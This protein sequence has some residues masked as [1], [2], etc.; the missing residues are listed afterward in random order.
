MSFI[1]RDEDVTFSKLN[2]DPNYI[3]MP[4]KPTGLNGPKEGDVWYDSVNKHIYAYVNGQTV[5][6]GGVNSLTLPANLVTNTNP[7]AATALMTY[8]FPA[9]A[10]NV[11]GRVIDIFGTGQ[12]TT[13]TGTTTTFAVTLGDGTNT[14]TALTWT[15]GA[16]T[17]AQ[18]NLQWELSGTVLITTAGTSG[19]V[20]SHG[21]YEIPLTAPSAA[22]SK[23]F[24][25]I[26]ANSSALDLSKTITLTVTSLF[27]SSN[28]SNSVT[29]DAL[30]ISVY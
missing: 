1:F 27:G 4:S 14:R 24:D 13:G 28:A 21:Y 26:T 5:T 30:V 17:T 3:A 7:T 8:A 23:Y 29:E 19:T 6:F 16:L 18:T 22:A 10:L 2:L 25:A 15:T 9:G 20:F 12:I 11:V